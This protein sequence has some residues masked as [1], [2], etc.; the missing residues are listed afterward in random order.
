MLFIYCNFISKSFLLGFK[1][2]SLSLLNFLN[3]WTTIRNLALSTNSKTYD[4]LSGFWMIVFIIIFCTFLLLHKP[5]FYWM[6]NIIN[7]TP[8]GPDIFIKIFYKYSWALF[9][10]IIFKLLIKCMILLGSTFKIWS[11]QEFI[12]RYIK[13]KVL[14][15]NS[16][17]DIE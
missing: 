1:I 3:M 12:F 11:D 10:W 14:I 17:G 2:Y 8:W 7:F 9:L 5:F 16:N 6:L 4:S 13:F 15:R